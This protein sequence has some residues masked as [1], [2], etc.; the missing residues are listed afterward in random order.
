M[1]AAKPE[2]NQV[3][4]EKRLER[5]RS[6]SNRLYIFE[7]SPDKVKPK[8]HNEGELADIKSPKSAAYLLKKEELRQR[9]REQL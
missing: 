8:N 5:E 9:R 4:R 1:F 7:Y 2:E 6:A 3:Q